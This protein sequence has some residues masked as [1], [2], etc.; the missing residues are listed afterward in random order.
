MAHTRSVKPAEG[1]EYTATREIF[2]KGFVQ[3]QATGKNTT[4]GY[5]TALAIDPGLAPPVALEFVNLPPSGVAAD[6]ITPFTVSIVVRYEAGQTSV[7]IHDTDGLRQV[8]ITVPP[9]L[10]PIPPKK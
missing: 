1:P 9:P 5:H 3:V 8:K 7:P 4:T 2:E 6:H 10:P